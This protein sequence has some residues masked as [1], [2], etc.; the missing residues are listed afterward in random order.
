M[1]PFLFNSESET[2]LQ[3]VTVILNQKGYRVVRGFDLRSALAAQPGYVYPCHGVKPC[4]C[5]FVVLLVYRGAVGPVV[6]MAHGHD[7][8]TYLQ[9][10]HDPVVSPDP[11]LVM[12]VLAALIEAVL[13]RSVAARAPALRSRDDTHPCC[14]ERS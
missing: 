12:Q 13:I 7:T 4:T 2:A 8:E 9:T 11:D 10:S 14:I 5:Q 6:V 1:I 3:T